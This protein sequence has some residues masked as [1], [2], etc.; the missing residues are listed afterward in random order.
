ME[1]PVKPQGCYVNL[2]SQDRHGSPNEKAG[3]YCTWGGFTDPLGH[4]NR[5]RKKQFHSN[6]L[7]CPAENA[8][9]K[10]TFWNRW[11]KIVSG[12]CNFDPSKQKVMIRVNSSTSCDSLP[13][14]PQCGPVNLLSF[15]FHPSPNFTLT[16]LH[17][18]SW[19]WWSLIYAFRLK[20]SS[21]NLAIINLKRIIAWLQNF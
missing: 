13:I 12:G 10:Q 7:L 6:S 21:N 4:C 2:L 1:T 14:L 11:K 17:S 5:D 3:R 16:M 15:S 9:V 20:N 18:L 19:P 8:N